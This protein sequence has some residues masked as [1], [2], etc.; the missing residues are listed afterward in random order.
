MFPLV[1]EDGRKLHK[2]GPAARGPVVDWEGVAFGPSCSLVEYV[3]GSY[4]V[5]EPPAAALLLRAVFDYEED[6]RW[7]VALCHSIAKALCDGNLLR[8]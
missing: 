5:I 6:P 2:R 8:A 7:F 1:A 4:R 3:R